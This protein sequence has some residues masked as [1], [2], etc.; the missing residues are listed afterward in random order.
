M[1]RTDYL[2]KQICH[3]H[4]ERYDVFLDGVEIA[5]LYLRW[6]DFTVTY[7]AMTDASEI[8]YSATPEDA[9]GEFPPEQ[10]NHFINEALKAID[11]RH[12][13]PAPVIVPIVENATPEGWTI[14]MLP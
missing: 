12:H 13:G 10:R 9:F 4:P 11:R 3:T 14:E 5:E 6:G 8:V 1:I 7:A 2:V